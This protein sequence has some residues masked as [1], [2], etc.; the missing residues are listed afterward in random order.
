MLA[1]RGVPEI[2]KGN[3]RIIKEAE[4]A[5][6]GGEWAKMRFY[7]LLTSFGDCVRMYEYIYGYFAHS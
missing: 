5:F 2:G 6:R 1:C 7:A 4:N 3:Y